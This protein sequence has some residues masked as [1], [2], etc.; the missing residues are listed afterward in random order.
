[1][2]FAAVISGQ[3]YPFVN[4]GGDSRAASFML[5]DHRGG[6]WVNSGG[7]LRYFDGQHFFALEGLEQ[8]GY[9]AE[10][11][12]GGIWIAALAK[13]LYRFHDGLLE[14]LY[15]GYARDLVA[16]RPGLVLVFTGPAG[17]ARPANPDLYRF[18]EHD[19][20]WT[21]TKLAD[22]KARSGDYP[23]VDRQR[24]VTYACIGGWC[25]LPAQTIADWQ[26][27][28]QGGPLRH[29]DLYPGLESV[30]RDRFGCVW[31][32]SPTTTTS[33][34][35]PGDEA[36]IA[37]PV[38]NAGTN[39]DMWED[40]D[41]SIWL[42][43]GSRLAVGRPGNFRVVRAAN[44]LPDAN[45][46]VV[47]PDGTPWVSGSN[48]LF[49]WQYPF[50]AEY[51]TAHDGL[52]LPYSPLRAS[53]KMFAISGP[54][55][56][57]LSTDRDRWLPL[58]ESSKLGGI[59]KLFPGPNNTLYATANRGGVAQLTFGGVIIA[60]SHAPLGLH[61]YGYLLPRTPLGPIWFS[62]TAISRVARYG[63]DLRLTSEPLTSAPDQKL[64]ACYAGGLATLEGSEIHHV[65]SADG[66]LENVCMCL[67]ILPNGDV[68]SAIFPPTPLP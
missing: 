42:P 65:S 39:L 15:G 37:L 68:C 26:S 2:V 30:L 11:S 34:Q 24:T 9:L 54:G 5:L 52:D 14:K 32:R 6:L 33:Y 27:G 59:R 53:G 47:S 48:G 50:R 31:F 40:E 1:M 21:G 51:W 3:Q 7:A 38:E 46:I 8:G 49:R 41:G 35:C 17:E 19:G 29:P 36:P 58:G 18:A 67:K 55:I 44:G 56:A 66:L 45:H 60:Q 62:D 13:G 61:P 28:Y 20:K 63:K 64:A 25:E 43:S 10:D 57:T 22:W 23:K 16:V 12:E 4:V